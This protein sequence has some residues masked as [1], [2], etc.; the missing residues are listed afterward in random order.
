M[1][2]R[3]NDTAR[4]PFAT[5]LLSAKQR[6]IRWGENDR[7]FQ[8]F[9]L[10][11]HFLL[12]ACGQNGGQRFECR[13]DF[14]KVVLYCAPPKLRKQQNQRS[15]ATRNHFQELFDWI[16]HRS[17]NENERKKD[18]KKFVPKQQS[19]RHDA[20]CRSWASSTT[21][22]TTTATAS[23]HN[24]PIEGPF[25]RGKTRECYRK[26]S[27]CERES[28]NHRNSCNRKKSIATTHFIAQNS[29]S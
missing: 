24:R 10:W 25:S 19:H 18:G 26:D 21:T 3:N 2:K 17:R 16:T 28:D 23:P 12:T 29:Y 20:L 13:E 15:V 11:L 7:E 27:Y 8:H 14:A 5:W 4:R 22:T 9:A 1:L 6:F